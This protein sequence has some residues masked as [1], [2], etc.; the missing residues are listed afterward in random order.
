M[1]CSSSQTVIDNQIESLIKINPDHV[2][3]IY[4]NALNTFDNCWAYDNI[5]LSNIEHG[6]FLDG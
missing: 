3:E 1:E 2:V 5:P 6:Q 4:R